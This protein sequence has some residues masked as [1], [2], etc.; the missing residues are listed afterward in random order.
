MSSQDEWPED[1]EE[2][3]KLAAEI[4]RRMFE[5]S[6]EILEAE[7]KRLGRKL[8]LGE[9]LEILANYCELRKHKP[10]GGI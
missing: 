10:E 4:Q 2:G 6:G 7:E 1:P 8:E 5:E 3:A 9:R